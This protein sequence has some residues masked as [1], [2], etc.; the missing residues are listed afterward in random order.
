M[1]RASPGTAQPAGRERHALKQIALAASLAGL[2]LAASASPAAASVTIGQVGSPAACSP[3]FDWVQPTVTSGNSYVVPSTGG[4]VSWTV[5]SWTTYGGAAG[6]FMTMKIWRKVADPATYRA[7]GHVGPESVTP[8]GTAGNTFPANLA[9]KAGDL[10]GLHTPGPGN[11]DCTFAA[12]GDEYGYYT[13][14]L[15]DGASGAFFFKPPPLD[16][17]RLNIEALLVPTVPQISPR[18]ANDFTFGAITRNKKKGTAVL[19]VNVPNAGELSGSGNGAKVASTSRAVISKAVGAGPARLLIKAK[20][21]K[22]KKLK[23]K[24]KVKVKVF[25]TYTPTGGDPSTQSVKVKL[26]K[27]RKKD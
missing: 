8:G 22:K 19:T 27:K 1:R 14:D 2:A 25:V 12:P 4:V 15:A 13:G 10:L 23:K 11:T 6:A 18:P 17:M 5:K 3:G 26:K 21:K 20:R 24:G 16:D 9:V 7:V